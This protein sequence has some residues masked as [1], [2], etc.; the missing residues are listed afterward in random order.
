[1]KRHTYTVARFNEL[2]LET[3]TTVGE[4]MYI[5]GEGQVTS[6]NPFNVFTGNYLD[7]D[8]INIFTK[9]SFPAYDDEEAQISSDW[10]LWG[11]NSGY[12][13]WYEGRGD[14]NFVN[15]GNGT[16]NQI[17]ASYTESVGDRDPFDQLRYAPICWDEISTFE[18]AVAGVEMVN[19][20]KLDVLGT[21]PTVPLANERYAYE[22]DKKSFQEIVNMYNPLRATTFE[23]RPYE[24]LFAT[25]E[26]YKDKPLGGKATQSI[27]L[28]NNQSIIM[29]IG[30]YLD[31]S[32]ADYVQFEVNITEYP[33]TKRYLW[34]TA[35]SDQSIALE[36]DG[37]ITF[38]SRFKKLGGSNSIS[39]ITA[40]RAI[41]LN[42]WTTVNVE[43][44]LDPYGGSHYHN[45]MYNQ[46]QV[47]NKRY[48]SESNVGLTITTVVAPNIFT[49]LIRN[50][51]IGV[52]DMYDREPTAT[53]PLDEALATDDAKDIIGSKTAPRVGFVQSDMI[54]GEP[55]PAE[56]SIRTLFD[57]LPVP[58]GTLN[59]EDDTKRIHLA[60]GEDNTLQSE[61]PAIFK[62]I[63][64][65]G[66]PVILG[67]TVIPQGEEGVK[68]KLEITLNHNGVIS[69]IGANRTVG[70]YYTGFIYDIGTRTECNT[71]SI[72]N[73]DE[74]GL[75]HQRPTPNVS[76]A[77]KYKSTV[78]NPNNW[79]LINK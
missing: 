45:I 34:G 70:N 48:E 31:G 42:Q 58:T 15:F 51:S 71:T 66:Q 26:N 5:R 20:I 6:E 36:S 56:P 35:T 75:M 14:A 16:H 41:P 25:L 64:F 21:N 11:D 24:T 46:V 59:E 32:S 22:F 69:R 62:E 4:V 44:W 29:P 67:T 2:S 49:G 54:A 50:V 7:R 57:A 53:F 28:G 76:R 33:P 3:G 17:K 79:K 77:F 39:S 27:T 10:M 65:D 61:F 72:Y 73:M 13:R 40:S 12:Y 23:V 38:K 55:I 1:M 74:Y 37:K 47:A 9:Q 63:K 68:H 30:V 8:T 19:T 60:I 78:Y 43:R 52:Y 18:K